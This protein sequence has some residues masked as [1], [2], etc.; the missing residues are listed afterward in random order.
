LKLKHL[1]HSVF[2]IPPRNAVAATIE[3]S[4]IFTCRNCL[5]P[6]IVAL[7]TGKVKRATQIG[8]RV[9]PVSAISHRMLVSKPVIGRSRTR[10]ACV[11]LNRYRTDVGR[12]NFNKNVCVGLAPS[13]AFTCG[14]EQQ[15]ADHVVLEGPKHRPVKVA[16][17]PAVLDEETIK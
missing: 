7:H 11:R 12:F 10:L 4:P 15:T 17:V 6:S 14:V 16:C 5:I 8:W 3:K 1:L 2:T 9:T 13:A